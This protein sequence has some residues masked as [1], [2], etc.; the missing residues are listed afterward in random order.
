MNNKT[1]FN[2]Q[3]GALFAMTAALAGCGGG[4]SDST[5]TTTPPVTLSVSGTVTAPG[6]ALALRETTVLEKMLAAVFGNSAVAAL[7]GTSA[8][9]GTTV[10]LIE[11][12]TTGA[13]VGSAL[14][15]A[16]TAS[17]GTFTVAAPSTFEAAAKYVLR[18]GSGASEMD[19][20]VTGTA[21]QDIDPATEAATD[22]V[23]DTVVSGGATLASLDVGQ[24]AGVIDTV[25]KL[26]D[27]VVDAGSIAGIATALTTEAQN[28]EEA[29]NVLESIAAD[30]TITGT[31]TDTSSAPLANIDVVVRD[32]SDWVT[33]AKTK[34]NSAGQYTVKVPSGNTKHYIVG[35]INHTSTSTAASEWWTAGG[36]AANQF[37]GEKVS[38][39]NTTA[40]SKDFVLDP[41]AQIK[42]VVYATDGTTPLGGVHVLVRDFSNDTPVAISRT[43]PDGKYLINV[44]PGSYTVGT[45]NQTLQAYVGGTYNGAAAG[46]TTT[47][48]TPG[49]N[50]SAATPIVVVAGDVI[51]AKFALPAG[52]E[53]SGVVTNPTPTTTPVTGMSVRFYGADT[54]PDA[55]NGAFVEG[56]KTNKDGG[57][58]M[59]VLPANDYTV[60]ARGQSASVTAGSSVSTQ[61][62]TSAV[63]Q[64][65]ATLT[66]D[67]S[68]PLSQVKVGVYD[69]TTFEYQGFETSNGDGTVTVYTS[70]SSDY[71]LE[72]KV[73]GGSTT[74]GSAIYDGPA[75]DSDP[76]AAQ[77][78][79]GARL[80][81]GTQV[82]F[83]ADS[84]SITE[85]GTLTMPVGG[86]LK[87]KIYKTTAT[88]GNE[89]ANAIV[90]VR[91]Y[92]T[93]GGGG[94]FRFISTRTQA[95]GSYS[96][97]L[98][99]G[100]TAYSR[101]CA[102]LPTAVS[103]CPTTA[104]GTGFASA[105]S[106]AVTASSSTTQ[107][108]TIP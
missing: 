66:T 51:T 32:F 99:P 86:E 88:A 10:S 106:V 101:V 96:I 72:L 42:G 50:A 77:V 35:A 34:T 57:Y 21:D 80:T 20:M 46:S 87:G 108:I 68:T 45:R 59:W 67:G 37:S 12:D 54:A 79:S 11:I 8:V 29:S 17:D 14:A 85:L 27:D 1:I 4:G 41:G 81:F 105:N 13:Q 94:G 107:D 75:T 7:P 47:V 2:T 82:T 40:I 92:N 65:T 28:Q 5:S 78:V 73:D 19:T 103:P 25:T 49:A 43:R 76:A 36:G 61:N 63:G 48:V 102:F 55:I 24:V 9:S 39:P 91:G 71:V 90:Q 33:R 64:A 60:R 69:G 3:C 97:S 52:R 70:A 16:T 62:F 30:G 31:V 104:S 84:T 89:Q 38:V 22:L 93:S 83:T 58:R 15:T 56:I 44:K 98:P 23:L 6:G 95:D 26:A 53:V 100:T 74:V 18:V